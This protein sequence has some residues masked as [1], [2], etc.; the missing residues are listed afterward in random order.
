M[1][2]ISEI[3]NYI[4]RTNLFNFVI[5]LAIIIF[6]CKKI[7]VTGKL[8]AAKKDVVNNIENSKTA[9]SDSESTL[10]AIEESVAH[11][12]E[13]IDEIIKKAEENARMVGGK[14]LED[15]EKSVENI[16][17]CLYDTIFCAKTQ[18]KSP[19]ISL[20]AFRSSRRLPIFTSRFQL[21]IFGT[22]ELNFCV[23]NGNRW[24][25]TVIVTDQSD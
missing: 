8:E 10:K 25:L 7:N 4:G 21:T 18:Q 23:R 6:V 17:F 13:E 11:I 19:E 5:F 3:I 14:I 24:D 22:S 16:K 2:S 15:A 9:K 20:R 12:E 1:E